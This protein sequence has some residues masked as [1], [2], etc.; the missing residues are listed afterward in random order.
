[1]P[2]QHAQARPRSHMHRDTHTH[3]RLLL[4]MLSGSNYLNLSAKQ[5]F[6]RLSCTRLHQADF[7]QSQHSVDT[8][9]REVCQ[10]KSA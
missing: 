10:S 5:K 3:I 4:L 9:C 7:I 1:M 2:K 6:N 8:S